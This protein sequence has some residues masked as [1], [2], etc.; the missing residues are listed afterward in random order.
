MLIKKENTNYMIFWKSQNYSN[1][2][3]INGFQGFEARRELGEV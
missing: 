3:K 1:G 2:K